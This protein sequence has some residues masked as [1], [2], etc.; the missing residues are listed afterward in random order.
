[1]LDRY[2]L[3]TSTC[4]RGCVALLGH[5][6]RLTMVH[7]QRDVTL[8]GI[9]MWF[10]AYKISILMDAIRVLTILVHHGIYFALCF[11]TKILH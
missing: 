4:A 9:L 11:Y 1:M 2:R 5:V 6:V 3:L 10:G 8:M 7:H